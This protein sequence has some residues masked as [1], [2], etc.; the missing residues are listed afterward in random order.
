MSDALVVERAG[1]AIR[2]TGFLDRHT[3]RTAASVPGGRFSASGPS[4]TWPLTLSSYAALRKAFAER[5]TLGPELRRWVRAERARKATL[6]EL[7]EHHDAE[8]SNV[9]QRIDRAMSTRSYQRVGAAFIAAAQSCLIADQPGLGKT[10]ELLAGMQ[11]ANPAG[12]RRWHLVLAPAVA[13]SAVWPGEVAHWCGRS[14]LA[15]PITGTAEQRHDKLRIALGCVA[16]VQDVY[17]IGNIEM[18]RIKPVQNSKGKPVFLIDNAAYPELFGRVWGSVTVDESHRALI[19]TGKPTQT[20]VGMT[21]L[22]S[23]RRVAL[24]GTPMR[25]KPEQLWGTLNWLRPDVYTSYWTWVAQYWDI[26][27]TKFSAYNLGEF[28]PGGE[29]RLAADLAGIMLRRTKT[30]VLT[31]LPPKL[32]AGTYLIPDDEQSPHGVWLELT[33]VQRKRLA[34]FVAEGTVRLPGGKLETDEQWIIANGVLAER[35]RQLQLAGSEGAIV[36]ETY[37]HKLPSP[38]FDWLLDKLEELGLDDPEHTDARVIVSS[39]SSDLLRLFSTQLAK[40]GFANHL[41]T[42]DTPSKARSTMAADFQSDHPCKRIFLLNAKA[43]GVSLTLDMADDLVMLDESTIPDEDEQVEDRA[44]RTSRMHQLTIY[45][46]RMLDTIEEEVSWVAAAR[47]DVQ[48]YIMDGSRG[49][50]YARKL[51]AEHRQEDH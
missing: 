18:V 11:E 5:I 49:C 24:S 38:K 50:E 32:Y 41:L 19:R 12:E 20:R 15:F 30:E 26:F 39:H 2:L 4:Y 27:P 9:S 29:D 44:H 21:K 33:E 25:G 46:L 10:I 23:K 31:E 45:R 28:S 6:S 3:Q 37:A 47:E 40:R 34:K 48:R 1:G 51:Y 22:V 7:A 13:V 14:A 17:V 43:G 35:T 8:L 16:D 42:G 36:N